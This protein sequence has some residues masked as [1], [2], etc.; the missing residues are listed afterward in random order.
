MKLTYSLMDEL[1]ASPSSPLPEAKRVYQLQRMRQG[2]HS[3]IQGDKPTSHD[4][5]V[6][7]D[8][9][10]LLETLITD[11]VAADNDGLI[12]EAIEAMVCASVAIKNKT[13][14]E[15]SDSQTNAIRAVLEDYEMC[16]NELPAR[17]II[18]TH[19]RTEKRL[20]EIKRGKRQP[21]DV[22]L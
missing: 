17:Q 5:S 20:L 21:Q 1:M 18:R 15:L 13:K 16:L 8:S 9:I 14:V 12:D 19:R 6:V 7:S 22:V 11:G 3:M 4:W 2:L 10:N